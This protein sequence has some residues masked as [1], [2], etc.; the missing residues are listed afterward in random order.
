MTMKGL[1]IGVVLA[2]AM[3]SAA[4]ATTLDFEGLAEG[5]LAPNTFAGV[6][7]SGGQVLTSGISLN[8]FEFPPKSGLNVLSNV[9]S[10]T[11]FDFSGFVTSFSAYVTGT[12]VVSLSL[13]DGV[14]LLGSAATGGANYVSAGTPNFLLSVPGAHITRALLSTAAGFDYTV[15]DVSFAAGAGVPEPATWALM[16]VGLGGLGL[17]LRRRRDQAAVAA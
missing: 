8:E 16:L 13:Y 15:D 7:I 10:Q 2:A 3:A 6:T 5:A 4:Q 9:G 11:S 12:G 1:F 17:A 14:T